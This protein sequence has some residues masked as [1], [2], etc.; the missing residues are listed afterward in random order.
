MKRQGWTD[1][2]GRR[3]EVITPG[4]RKGAHSQDV[5]NTSTF[6]DAGT[7]GGRSRLSA[8]AISH[9]SVL[10]RSASDRTHER[11]TQDASPSSFLQ[12]PPLSRSHS[13]S[14]NSSARF[15]KRRQSPALQPLPAALILSSRATP[16]HSRSASLTGSF[17][18]PE[19]QTAEVRPPPFSAPVPPSTSL[20][21]SFPARSESRRSSRA[22]SVRYSVS[23]GNGSV[24]SPPGTLPPLEFGT[25]WNT[26]DLLGKLP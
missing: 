13:T 16:T 5:V 25:S 3:V 26:E 18:G 22:S 8:S 21:P 17:V 12:P 19:E 6:D 2:N 23:G 7:F 11:P 24:V 9:S 14:S 20:S 15:V 4:H 10:E 1:P